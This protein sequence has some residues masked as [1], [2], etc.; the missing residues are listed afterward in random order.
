MN[1]CD[2]EQ[3][4]SP[5]FST[6]GNP[7]VTS[8]PSILTRFFH[9]YG[10]GLVVAS[11]SVMSLA[12]VAV[13]GFWFGSQK[14]ADNLLGRDD[15]SIPAEILRATA[16]HGGAN[17]AVATGPV[18]DDTDGI[19]FLDYIT[20]DLQ[21]WVYYPRVQQFGAKFRTNITQQLPAQKNAEYL[22]V[23]GQ[24]RPAA[25]ASNQRPG[26]CL[27]YVIDVKSGLFAAYTMPWTTGAEAA[28]QIQDGPLIVVDGGQY[29][30]PLPGGGVKK[31]LGLSKEK[32]KPGADKVPAANDKAAPGK[33]A[34]EK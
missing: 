25:G 2:S 3:T 21:C 12:S 10:G 33:D 29:R 6:V 30:N 15:R 22:L 26:G 16:T 19:F 27:V 17:L 20:G 1:L 13:L 5:E 9:V 11:L 32:E 14:T 31:P 8:T 23:V 7:I 4:K 28:G 24:T 34:K 18:S